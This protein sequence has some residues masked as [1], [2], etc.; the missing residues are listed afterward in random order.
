MSERYEGQK[1]K[2]FCKECGNFW[3]SNL[4]FEDLCYHC[5]SEHIYYKKINKN[6]RVIFEHF[7]KKIK[8]AE[9][10]LEEWRQMTEELSWI[11]GR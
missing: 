5:E 6:D 8:Q 7:R 4:G 11:I 1:H 10:D 9:A 2:W 3:F